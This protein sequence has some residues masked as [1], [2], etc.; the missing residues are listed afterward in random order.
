MLTKINLLLLLLLLR[1][2]KRLAYTLLALYKNKVERD[3]WPFDY[4]SVHYIVCWWSIVSKCLFIIP[5]EKFVWFTL[6]FFS[7]VYL[8]FYYFFFICLF[9]F[10]TFFFL[11]KEKHSTTIKVKLKAKVQSLY[12][13]EQLLF[14]IFSIQNFDTIPVEFKIQNV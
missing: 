5:I 7:F 12:L 9:S 11:Y 10:Y 13:S 4:F 1:L 14:T 8:K 6:N 3:T 2:M